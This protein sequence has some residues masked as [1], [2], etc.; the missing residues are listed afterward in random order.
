MLRTVLSA[1]EKKIV[2]RMPWFSPFSFGINNSGIYITRYFVKS[3]EY[4]YWGR[5]CKVEFKDH[6]I[7]HKQRGEEN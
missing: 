6:W 7:A 2:L 5:M 4:F 3:L 1:V